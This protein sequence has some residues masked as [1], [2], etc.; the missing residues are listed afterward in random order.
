LEKQGINQGEIP[1]KLDTEDQD[2]FS[3][4][5]KGILLVATLVALAA[6]GLYFNNF[7][8][9]FSSDQAIWGT[10]GDYLGGVLNPVFGF[11]GLLALLITIALQSKELKLSR[12]ELRNS[13]TALN[14]QNQTLKHQN[15]ESSFFQMLRI[16]NDIVNSIDFVRGG[17][18]NNVVTTTGRDCF[19]IMVKRLK[20]ILATDKTNDNEKI[21]A[22]K[23]YEQFYVRHQVELG[24]YYRYLYN[25]FKFI[26]NS[27]IADKKFYSNLVRAQISN[28]ELVIIFYNCLS[29]YGNEKFWPLV[30]EFSI[31][32]NMPTSL[33]LQE[34]HQEW[35]QKSI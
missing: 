17:G 11:L 32:K 21:K 18:T 12:E 25:I 16:H 26:H 13:S 22:T 35:V 1:V 6:L 14:A 29:K 8:E 30:V 20:V 3:T 4:I 19:P 33:L 10:F 5:L 15:F 28:H 24:H 2:S 23:A 34:E 27:E 7:N 9:G 31:L